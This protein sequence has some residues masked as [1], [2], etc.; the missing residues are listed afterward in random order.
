MWLYA[1]IFRQPGT[2]TR[3]PAASRRHVL[4]RRCTRRPSG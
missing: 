4:W 1:A 3:P 2:T